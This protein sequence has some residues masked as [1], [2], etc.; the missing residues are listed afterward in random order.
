MHLIHD[1]KRKLFWVTVKDLLFAVDNAN[2]IGMFSS[3]SSCRKEQKDNG[4]SSNQKKS[5]CQKYSCSYDCSLLL[6]QYRVSNLWHLLFF[7]GHREQKPEENAHTLRNM[8][9]V[10]STVMA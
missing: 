1:K 6:E 10:T 5:P 2:C 8:V 3:A 7:I 4:F 9:V